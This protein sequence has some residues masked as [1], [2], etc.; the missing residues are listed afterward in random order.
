[1]HHKSLIA[2]KVDV[3]LN[4]QRG[5]R[6]VTWLWQVDVNSHILRF[7]S[8]S[9][10]IISGWHGNSHEVGCFLE[11]V[12]VCCPIWWLAD[13][14]KELE[15]GV[16]HLLFVFHVAAMVL[17][18]DEWS[19]SFWAFP[20]HILRCAIRYKEHKVPGQD[21]QA[22]TGWDSY[23]RMTTE[24]QQ[25]SLILSHHMFFDLWNDVQ[26]DV[27]EGGRVRLGQEQETHKCRVTSNF[28]RPNVYTGLSCRFR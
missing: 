2:A 19:S 9:A 22:R 20:L 15:G 26:R 23:R 27:T 5:I 10:F 6:Y 25:R 4:L 7:V 1:M 12:V 11:W 18:I 17:R 21:G 14:S 8:R 16:L 13:W 24:V 28:S 3:F